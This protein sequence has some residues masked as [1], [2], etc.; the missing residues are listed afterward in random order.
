MLTRAPPATNP[1]FFPTVTLLPLT[2]HQ[3]FAHTTEPALAPTNL[4]PTPVVALDLALLNSRDRVF[5]EESVHFLLMRCVTFP[6]SPV[7]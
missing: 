7:Q 2:R 5:P 6:G 1:E 3:I 4:A